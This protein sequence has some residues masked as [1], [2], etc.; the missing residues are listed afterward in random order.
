MPGYID[1]EEIVKLTGSAYAIVYPSL[2]EGFG[3][4]VLEAMNCHVPALT[5][6]NSAMEEI[7]GDAAL[8]F[9][10]KN[11]EDIAEK[12]MRIYKDEDLRKQLIEKG[13]SV[14]KQYSWDKT[15]E[16]LWNCIQKTVI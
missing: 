6:A 11:H 10:P 15:A 4:P 14:S 9:D 3:V 12:M 2:W 7:A 13:K 16:L 8:Y 5:S 1:E